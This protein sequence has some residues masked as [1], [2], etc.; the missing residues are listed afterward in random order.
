MSDTPE[1][2]NLQELLAGYVLGDLDEAELAWLNQQLAVNSQLEEEIK[3]LQE[4][5]AFMPYGLSP[6]APSKDL[7][8][9]I[10]ASAATV[11][12]R[13]S[14]SP[15]KLN[16]LGWLIAAIT[17]FSTILFGF[18]SYKLRYQL[19]LKETGTL[20]QQELTALL[21]QPN[22]RLMSLKGMEELTTA[23]GS[24][25]IVPEQQKAML[26]LQNLEPLPDKKFYRLWAV[27]QGQKTG[28][29]NFKPDEKG[30][31]KVELSPRELTNA[32]SVLITIES[33]PDTFQP[34]GNPIITSY[35][36]L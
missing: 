31:V 9:R 3:Q 32:Q 22:N 27:S 18:N 23:S 28:C 5:L 34:T 8:G 25:F 10:L 6:E 21:R 26:V 33:Q 19:T 1:S 30:L 16:R 24:L 35:Q 29:I 20:E 2:Y 15:F 17:T 4:T 36:S 7:R 12:P 14:S 11:N 13:P